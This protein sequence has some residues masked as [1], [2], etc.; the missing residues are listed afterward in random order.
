MEKRNI[1]REELRV[2][3]SL[4][5][6]ELFELRG[7]FRQLSLPHMLD[8]IEYQYGKEEPTMV[9]T[10]GGGGGGGIK[11]LLHAFKPPPLPLPKPLQ[12]MRLLNVPF[13][14]PYRRSDVRMMTAMHLRMLQVLKSDGAP[15]IGYLAQDADNLTNFI[16]RI[17][18]FE[19]VSTPKLTSRLQ[20]YSLWAV[21]IDK[22][23][24]DFDFGL[25]P[26]EILE[27][28][29]PDDDYVRHIVL[30]ASLQLA[31]SVEPDHG[32]IGKPKPAG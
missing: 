25:S 31:I 20:T 13:V 22:H 4:G 7:F 8:V 15:A 6:D 19:A 18:G 12:G 21:E 26:E 29:I 1:V 24:Q 2:V 14:R 27:G 23:M 16:L 3:T 9:W 30:Q 11:G 32:I 17:W 10:C 28:S 5:S